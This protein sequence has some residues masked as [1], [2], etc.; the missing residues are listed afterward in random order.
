MGYHV[1][2]HIDDKTQIDKKVLHCEFI[3]FEDCPYG[4]R[5]CPIVF[6]KSR[7]FMTVHSDTGD[8][9]GYSILFGHAN[10]CT[11]VHGIESNKEEEYKYWRYE[12]NEAGH[13]VSFLTLETLRAKVLATKRFP[14]SWYKLNKRNCKSPNDCRIPVND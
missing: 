4:C 13:P 10:T 1:F 11:K 2:P 5:L 14:K 9:S 3:R 8:F 12:I 7:Q 6:Y